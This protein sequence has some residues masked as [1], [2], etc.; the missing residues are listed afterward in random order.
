MPTTRFEPITRYALPR[1]G[2]FRV[3]VEGINPLAASRAL[4][5]TVNALLV[6]SYTNGVVT[7]DPSYTALVSSTAT[8][9]AVQL[10]PATPGASGDALVVD[11]DYADSFTTSYEVSAEYIRGEVTV[12]A[13]YPAPEQTS[14]GTN[15][16]LTLVAEPQAPFDFVDGNFYVQGQAALSNG[17]PLRPEYTGRAELSDSLLILDLTQ[18]RFFDAN[19]RVRVHAEIVITPDGVEEYTAGVAWAFHTAPPVTPLRD[20]SLLY[21]DVDRP[22]SSVGYE[23]FRRAAL[24][25]LRP[26]HSKAAYVVLLYYGVKN[27]GLLSLASQVPAASSLELERLLPTDFVSVE[28]VAGT[29]TSLEPFWTPL[30]DEL[31]RASALLP[32]RAALLHR[33]WSSGNAVDKVGAVCAAL[34]FGAARVV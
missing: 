6:F 7:T 31:V 20:P 21:T 23:M 3:V 30:L 12:K 32:E 5:V 24:G 1:S 34:L 29:L 9:L 10:T 2:P 11:A 16:P 27:S 18:R 25:A 14:V 15:P 19:T 4:D 17:R 26:E 13:Q 33:A 22:H 28:Y 8:M